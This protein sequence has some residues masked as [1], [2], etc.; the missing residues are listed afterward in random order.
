MRKAFYAIAALATAAVA[1]GTPPVAAQTVLYDKSRI[2]CVSRQM[3][4]PVEA[5]FKKFSAQ[6]A[7]DPAKPTEGKAR[8]DIDLDSFDIDNAEVNDEAVGK[9]WFDART[10]PKATFVATAIKPLG[11]GRFEV[12]GPLTIKGRTHEVSAPFSYK[13]EGG[14]AIVDGAFP[15]KRLQ[16]NIGEGVWKDT[17]TVA[18][19]VQI[20]FHI[21]MSARKPAE[22]K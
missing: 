9:Q 10:H 11:G 18:D 13:E 14:T 16:Y 17:D 4:V 7:F 3:N 8:I 20:K 15:I 6:I 1:V 12:R 22:K 21:V 5:R 2:T 19:D